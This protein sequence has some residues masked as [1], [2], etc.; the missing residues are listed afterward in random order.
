MLAEVDPYEDTEEQFAS[1]VAG[2]AET[3]DDEEQ[4][5]AGSTLAEARAK[6]ESIRPATQQVLLSSPIA[7]DMTEPDSWKNEVAH[8]LQNYKARRRRSLGDDSL[9]FNFES[10]AGNHVFLKPEF[11][12]EPE[13]KVAVPAFA[14][15]EVEPDPSYNATSV[16]T[17][18]AYEDHAYEEPVPEPVPEEIVV[19]R[20]A[21]VP[22]TAKLILFPRPPMMQEPRRDELADPV[23]DKPRIVEAP[24]VVEH[25][26]IPLAGITLRPEVPEDPCTPYI[27]PALELP[28][29][30]A[31]VGQ[32]VFAELL[33]TMLVMV[34]VGLFGM[35]LLQSKAGAVVND[36]HS[37][38]ELAILVP[39]IFWSFYKYLFFVY[40]GTT[41]GMQMGRLRLITFDGY[42]PSRTARRFRALSMLISIFP[43]GLGLLW[44]FVDNETLCWHDRISRTYMTGR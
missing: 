22:E 20:K 1:S 17:A 30:V 9:S 8:R 21:V 29:Q 26:A 3:E 7:S 13:P 25:V 32:R 31:P 28:A 37:L 39:V 11:E 43:L 15:A 42:Q 5:I 27:E 35:I 36:R 10:T 18:H 38:I 14:D 41:P 33:D 19:P 16:A 4:V 40:S 44:S 23:F 24:E 6:Y 34:A 2:Q 12:P